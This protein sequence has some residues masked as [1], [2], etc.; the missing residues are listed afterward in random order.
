[1]TNNIVPGLI[2]K[3]GYQ[4]APSARRFFAANP[5]SVINLLI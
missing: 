5:E 4:F 1:M 3:A 2:A